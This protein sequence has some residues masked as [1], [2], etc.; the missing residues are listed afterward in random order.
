MSCVAQKIHYEGRVQGVGFRYSVRQIAKGF[1]VTG[2]VRNLPD[3]RVEL[4]V[5][6]EA[7][8]VTDFLTAIRE[9]ALAGHIA[10]EYAENLSPETR[11]KGFTI[12]QP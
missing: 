3:D 8:E 10:R 9:S 6:G 2:T 1:D 5:S 4:C 7:A 11:W 12:L